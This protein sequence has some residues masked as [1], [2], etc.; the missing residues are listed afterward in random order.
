LEQQLKDDGGA[1]TAGPTPA[2]SIS[3]NQHGNSFIEF[4]VP[5]IFWSS[6]RGVL[7]DV[8]VLNLQLLRIGRINAVIMPV[9]ATLICILLVGYHLKDPTQDGQVCPRRL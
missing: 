1:G 4:A 5:V 9:L 2:V 3:H 6:D 7:S 8:S